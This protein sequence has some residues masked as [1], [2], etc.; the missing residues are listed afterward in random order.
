MELNGF[1]L[2]MRCV[3]E[4]A[5]KILNFE[6]TKV[7][8]FEVPVE[9]LPISMLNSIKGMQSGFLNQIVLPKPGFYEVGFLKQF[10]IIFRL[11]TN[12]LLG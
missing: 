3:K 6:N 1:L 8:I 2:S 7:N 4:N 12:I 9:F 10:M 11:T 5:P